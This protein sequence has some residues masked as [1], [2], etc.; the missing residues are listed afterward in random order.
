MPRRSRCRATPR[1]ALSS[2][3]SSEA[4]TDYFARRK[5][6]IMP[7]NK[8]AS[9]RYRLVVRIA[10][11]QVRLYLARSLGALLALSRAR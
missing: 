6:V 8:F 3:R 9:P 1:S 10:N 5:M 7:K 4:K 11:K 2:T